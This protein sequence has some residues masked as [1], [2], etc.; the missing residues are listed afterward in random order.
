MR[1]LSIIAIGAAVLTLSG[2]VSPEQRAANEC[3]YLSGDAY[4]RCY[5]NSLAAQRAQGTALLQDGL[6]T[7]SNPPQP[8]P[9]Q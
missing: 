4:G 9:A 3:Q 2:C 1:I 8:Q 7:L 5:A 6:H